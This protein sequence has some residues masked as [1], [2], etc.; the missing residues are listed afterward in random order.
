MIHSSGVRRTDLC[1]RCE[2]AMVLVQTMAQFGPLPETRRYRCT[3]C[4]CVL[5]EEVHRDGQPISAIKFAGLTDW[6]GS[7]RVVN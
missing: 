7:R 6:L 5:D 4:P 3:E 2:T 1:P